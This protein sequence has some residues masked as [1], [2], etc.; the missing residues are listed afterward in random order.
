MAIDAALV[1]LQTESEGLSRRLQDARERASLAVGNDT[2]EYLSREPSRLAGLKEFENEMG[3]AAD[4]LKILDEQ[5]V[6]LRFVRAT[7]YS[8]FT[9]FSGGL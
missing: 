9:K 7:F 8:R 4:R 3:V 6:N 5:I 1:K 2:D